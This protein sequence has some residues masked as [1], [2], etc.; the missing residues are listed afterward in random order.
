M[1]AYLNERM[2]DEE[3]EDMLTESFGTIQIGYL[4]FDAGRILRELDPIAFNCCRDAIGDRWVCGKCGKEY[5]DDE[6]SAETCCKEEGT[7]NE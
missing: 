6:D 7:D 4:T 1:N 3:V 2:I 5:E